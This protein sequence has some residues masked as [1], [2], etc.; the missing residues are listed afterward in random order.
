M[1]GTSLPELYWLPSPSRRPDPQLK[2][3]LTITSHRNRQPSLLRHSSDPCRAAG[4]CSLT[5]L[6]PPTTFPGG[7][8]Q[9][10]PP[11]TR[12]ATLVPLLR[13]PAP[14]LLYPVP[15]LRPPTPTSARSLLPLITP[16]QKTLQWGSTNI[17]GSVAPSSIKLHD[18]FIQE[19]QATSLHALLLQ[20]NALLTSPSVLCQL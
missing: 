13:H 19:F 16:P 20:F 14:P 17:V 5:L 18:T 3:D 8:W 9:R 11:V 1:P 10:L 4:D 6:W 2:T 12:R 7:G 15:A